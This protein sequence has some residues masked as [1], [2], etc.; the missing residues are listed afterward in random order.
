[1]TLPS[2]S[3]KAI[4]DGLRSDRSWNWD[5]YWRSRHGGT[6]R[7]RVFAFRVLAPFFISRKW[8]SNEPLNWEFPRGC[9][10]GLERGWEKAR[11]TMLAPRGWGAPLSVGGG[12]GRR[13]G[14][15][16]CIHLSS[17]SMSMPCRF[18]P[19]NVS[20]ARGPTRCMIL[21]ARAEVIRSTP[22]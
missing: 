8:G 2:R 1:M 13:R 16:D 6:A 10:G 7:A 19:A 12:R 20:T 4:P 9:V 3:D 17:W 22:Y 5:S 15:I 14:W 21:E 18:G 11:C